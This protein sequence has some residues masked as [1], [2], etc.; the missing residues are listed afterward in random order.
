MDLAEMAWDG[1]EW[2]GLAQDRDKRGAV[3]NV[4]MNLL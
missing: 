1:V 4:V 2:L 3:V